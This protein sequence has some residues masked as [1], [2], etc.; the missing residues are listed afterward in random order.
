MKIITYL[1]LVLPATGDHT[2]PEALCRFRCLDE[3]C[4]N[5]WSVFISLP[6]VGQEV[7]VLRRQQAL[8]LCVKSSLWPMGTFQE[9][10]F[11]LS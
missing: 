7:K 10:S 8:Q 9:A 4:W 11:Q 2:E 5:I 1:N 3:I 6:A